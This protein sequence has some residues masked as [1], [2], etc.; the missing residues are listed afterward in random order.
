MKTP[1]VILMAVLLTFPVLLPL[2]AQDEPAPKPAPEKEEKKKEEPAPP[3]A[4]MLEAQKY[5]PMQK[6]NWWEYKFENDVTRDGSHQP[7]KVRWEVVETGKAGVRLR[8]TEEFPKGRTGSYELTV[9]VKD[10][11][12]FED[13]SL[14][15]TGGWKKLKLPP[16]KGDKWKSKYAYSDAPEIETVVE[17]SVDRIGTVETPLGKFSNAVCVV[18][19]WRRYQIG[20]VKSHTWYAPGVGMVKYVFE[21]P[22]TGADTLTLVKYRVKGV[23]KAILAQAVAASELVVIASVKKVKIKDSRDRDRIDKEIDETIAERMAQRRAKRIAKG[24]AVHYRLVVD[25]ALKGKL[26]EKEIVVSVKQE[27]GEG[28]WVLFL[29]KRN[30]GPYPVVGPMLP[31]GK[32]TVEKLE[33]ILNPPRPATLA[34]KLSEADFVILG[35]AVVKEERGAFAYWVFKIEKALKGD[36]SRAHLD[37][38]ITEGLPF[39]KGERYILALKSGK[40][41]GRK[42]YEVVGC[43]AH[44]FSEKKLQE[45][46]KALKK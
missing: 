18:S 26:K 42:F 41:H 28:K 19:S 3:P 8:V 31:A 46:E 25:K 45:Y 23:A 4:M 5:F 12:I 10:G 33:E 37:V 35:K 1:V 14:K 7:G 22:G 30:D 20:P 44:E 16:K 32:D 36:T 27:I 11:F 21:G 6:G 39:L 2:A 17:H 15:Y 40:H 24:E 38:L 43:E 13:Y 29:G 9:K 34:E